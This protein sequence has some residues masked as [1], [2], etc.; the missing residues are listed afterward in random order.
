MH[1]EDLAPEPLVFPLRPG[2]G[3]VALHATGF[4]HPRGGLIRRERFTAYA[5]LTHLATSGRALRI[6][7]RQ[8]VFL[9]PRA[10]FASPQAPEALVRALLERVVREPTGAVQ[11]ARMTEIEE[12]ARRPASRLATRALVI[13]CLA[14]FALEIALGP[15]VH[16]AGF[17]SAPLVA[18]GE[19]WRV[20]TGNL[21]HGGAIHLVLNVLCLLVL[22]ALVERAL[23]TGRTALVMGLAGLG[24]MA[25]SL[26]VGYE[27]MVGAS[28]IVAGLAGALL[29][30]ELRMPERLP[31]GWRIPRRPFVAALL[32]DAALPLFFPV[33]AG[34]AHL[35]GFL[36]GAA[37]TMVVTGP[38]LRR[39]PLQPALRVAIGLLLALGVAS[40][41]S[42]ARLVAGGP[43]W[44]GHAERLLALDDPSALVL[45]DAAWLIATGTRPAREALDEALELAERAVDATGRG[46]PNILDTLAEVQFQ[47]GEPESAVAT[48]DEAIALAP[49]EPYFREQRR[50]FTGERDPADRPPPPGMPFSV[51]ERPREPAAPRPELGDDPGISV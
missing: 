17:F 32:A 50:R 1:A 43:V 18:A 25:A 39:E 15:A 9:I 2:R 51:P 21:L 35:G 10:W 38:A 30:L 19:P 3:G 29:F 20:V 26:A 45:N 46:D 16:H 27:A 6:G 42:A 40:V 36:A 41:F 48:I 23:G 11:L 4:R 44:E 47:A 28:G 13:A 12:L 33:I 7:T 5:D 49:D 31:A 14:A 34:A 22:G 37:A 24:A 8:S